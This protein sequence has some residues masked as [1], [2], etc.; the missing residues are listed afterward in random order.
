MLYGSSPSIDFQ[1]ARFFYL[2]NNFSLSIQRLRRL[3]PNYTELA[4]ASL[5]EDVWQMFYPI[6]FQAAVS[7]EAQTSR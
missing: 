1:V 7:R 5:P 2:D 3:L 6:D 4:Y